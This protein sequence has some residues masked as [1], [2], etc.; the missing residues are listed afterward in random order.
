M[1]IFNL[2]SVIK[3]LIDAISKALEMIAPDQITPEEK[4]MWQKYVGPVYA[5]AK[6]L[7]P[8][9]VESTEND[10]D[11]AVLNEL[12]EVCELAATKY[13]FT[14]DPTEL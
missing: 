1:A 11:D 5:L 12:I 7:G 13:G 3:A 8:G 9:L 10:V 4:A 6:N 14:L 2:S